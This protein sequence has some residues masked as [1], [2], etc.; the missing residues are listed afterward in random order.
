MENCEWENYFHLFISKFKPAEDSLVMIYVNN[1][2]HIFLILNRMSQR[3][4]KGTV[5]Y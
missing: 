3:D 1:F 5:V 4:G 2:S